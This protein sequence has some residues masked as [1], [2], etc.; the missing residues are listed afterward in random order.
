MGDF[1][2]TNAFNNLEID[3]TFGLT[4]NNGGAVEVTGSLLLTDG[5]ITTSLTNTLTI[6]NSAINCVTPAGGSS[7]SYV[8]G[9]LSKMINIGDDFD[10]PVGKGDVP[11]N[12]FALSATQ[13]TVPEIWT[14]EF[15]TPN[16][17]AGTI[18]SPLTYVNADEYWKV[19][20]TG[21][22]ARINIDWDA[23]SDLTPLM[24][25][26]GL[27]DMRVVEYNTAPTPGWIQRASNASGNN[28]N[29]TVSTINRITIPTADGELDFTT[30]CIN[31]VKPR[32]QFAPTGPVCGTAGIPVNFTYSGAIPLDYTLD[33]SID[34]ADQTQIDITLA[35]I[36]YTLPTP[37]P[38]TYKLTAFTY[39]SGAGI[40]VV[41]PSEVI[42]YAEPT[43]AAA[44]DDQSLCG[45]TSATLEGNTPVIGTGLWIIESG[46]GGTV[47]T[48][49]DPTSTFN[50]TNGT[51]YTLRWTISNGDCESFDDVV[52]SFPLLPVQPEDFTVSSA[53]V[54][55]GEQDVIYTVPNDASVTYTWDYSSI[56]VTI[57]GT[58]NS[59]SVD[60]ANNATTGTLG[61][62]ATNGCGTSTAREIDI[63]VN[64]TPDTGAIYHIANNWGV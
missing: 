46:T 28:S 54:C 45:A 12:K 25:E 1:N 61:V 58:G 64:I 31:V 44:G 42:V 14:V 6:T 26:N 38:G 34:G 43:T 35:D 48:P 41:D 51:T 23:N 56:G 49:T 18:T 62:T 2:G 5:L 30:G 63:T 59:V 60:F 33:Y 27:S 39:N 11:G 16:L 13:T 22:S 52:I 7:S 10:F 53:I 50:G 4:I 55:Q 15:F 36:P 32:A 47:V 9:P 3:N 57:T 24:T 8:D 17:T 37:I 20:T 19:S 29:G 40:G 21:S